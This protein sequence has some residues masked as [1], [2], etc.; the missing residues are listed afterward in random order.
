MKEDGCND[1]GRPDN[2]QRDTGWRERKAP[3]SKAEVRTSK[4]PDECL[5]LTYANGHRSS[6][7]R[8]LPSGLILQGYE[9]AEKPI[10]E[11]APNRTAERN[12]ARCPGA[13]ARI[14]TNQPIC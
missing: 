6:L 12:R 3:T 2:E 10:A 9:T 13:I 5:P 7:G 4:Q 8:Q 11:L 14:G 1:D